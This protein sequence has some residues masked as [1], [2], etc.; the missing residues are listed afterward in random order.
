MQIC[1][2]ET[3]RIESKHLNYYNYDR[4]NKFP[5]TSPIYSRYFPPMTI[6]ISSTNAYDATDGGCGRGLIIRILAGSVIN[7]LL[8]SPRLPRTTLIDKEV[9]MLSPR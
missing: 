2:R 9:F 8:L 5:E 6:I 1:G 4:L 3:S 7:V